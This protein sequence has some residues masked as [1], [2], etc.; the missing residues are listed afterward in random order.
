MGVPANGDDN[1]RMETLNK[2]GKA[3]NNTTAEDDEI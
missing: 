1:I 3:A 2:E